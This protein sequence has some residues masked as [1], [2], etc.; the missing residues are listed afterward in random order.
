MRFEVRIA[1]AVF[2]AVAGAVLAVAGEDAAGGV[3][4]LASAYGVDDEVEGAFVETVDGPQWF[5]DDDFV[6]AVCLAYRNAVTDCRWTL[7]YNDKSQPDTLL[8]R[9]QPHAVV[10]VE[11]QHP[12][13]PSV[14]DCSEPSAGEP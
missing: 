1:G 14:V 7:S 3:V 6:G 4:D 12:R 2:V 13:P 8:K 11:N 9:Q 10:S 5:T